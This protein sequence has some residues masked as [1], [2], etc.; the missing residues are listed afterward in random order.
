TW[1]EHATATVGVITGPTAPTS[2]LQ[3]PAEQWNLGW[4][5]LTSMERANASALPDEPHVSISGILTAANSSRV[6]AIPNDPR[7]GSLG[8]ELSPTSEIEAP[9]EM[10]LFDASGRKLADSVPLFGGDPHV[11]SFSLAMDAVGPSSAVYV[12]VAAPSE[13]FGSGSSSSS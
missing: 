11:L 12:K 3:E 8:I 6:F 9:I 5:I 10:A 2:R 13:S 4:M 7:T 1:S